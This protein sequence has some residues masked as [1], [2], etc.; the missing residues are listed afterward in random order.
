MNATQGKYPA[1]FD[2]LLAQGANPNARDLRGFTALHRAAEMGK[3]DLVKK[4]LEHGAD[5]SLYAE[6]HTA[7]SLAEARKEAAI[8]ALLENR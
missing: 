6:G 8:V 7:R 3:L 1:A 2:F 4:L 5:A